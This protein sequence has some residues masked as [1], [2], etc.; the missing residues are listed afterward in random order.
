MLYQSVF[1]LLKRHVLVQ[2]HVLLCNLVAL[3]VLSQNHVVP[4]VLNHAL[5]VLAQA[6]ILAVIVAITVI[7]VVAVA[8]KNVLGGS[9]GKTKIAAA[10]MIA[11]DAD[12]TQ[13]ADADVTTTAVAMIAATNF[14]FAV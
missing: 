11:A 14:T 9:S 13:V 2:A 6:V 12:A 1:K 5:H 3:L 8:V 10:K 7:T 4:L